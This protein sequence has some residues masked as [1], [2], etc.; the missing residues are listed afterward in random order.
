MQRYTHGNIGLL[1]VMSTFALL[2][3]AHQSGVINAMSSPTLFLLLLTAWPWVFSSLLPLYFG[4]EL[5]LFWYIILQLIGLTGTVMYAYMIGVV[6][7]GFLSR[8]H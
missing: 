6:V 4:F 3:I 1:A 2:M 5:G 7:G 8:K